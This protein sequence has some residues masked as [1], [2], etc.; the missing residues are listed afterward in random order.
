MN[1]VD[2]DFP[3][4]ILNS[5]INP[6]YTSSSFTAKI[7]M[8][9][10][11][12]YDLVM[13][14]NVGIPRSF[15]NIDKFNNKFYIKENDDPEIEISLIEG[16][17]TLQNSEET[18]SANLTFKSIRGWT[19]SLKFIELNHKWLFTITNAPDFSKISLKFAS[20]SPHKLF[21]FP[22]SNDFKD[23][24]TLFFL[25]PIVMNFEKTKYIT[26]KSDIAHNY[27]NSDSDSQILARIPVHKTVAFNEIIDFSLNQI[28]DGAKNI[29]DNNSNSY[30]FSLFDDEENPMLLNGRHWFGTLVIFSHN[31]LR[32]E[33]RL[34][35]QQLEE[36]DYIRK[37]RR[38]KKLQ[39]GTDE[40][41]IIDEDDFKEPEN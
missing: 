18:L 26:V 1:I 23:Y 25:S 3:S 39:K 40:S 36:I 12:K 34:I 15:Y 27:G 41:L 6:D 17:Y 5:E 32:N 38:K 20:N 33:K 24:T 14:A 8:K 7:E 22:K 13:L 31:N 11:N 9:K 30:S 19:Y 2:N 29:H 37:E 4:F 28:L 16:N 35:K 10:N 21:G